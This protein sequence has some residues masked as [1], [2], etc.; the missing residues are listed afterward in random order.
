MSGVYHRL[1]KPATSSVRKP[2]ASV[3]GS[4]HAN[5]RSTSAQDRP[6]REPPGTTPSRGPERVRRGASPAPLPW[7]E[8]A[9]GTMSPVLGRP[10]RALRSH[11]VKPEWGKAPRRRESRQWHRERPDRTKRGAPR[12]DTRHAREARRR[13][14]PRHTDRCQATAAAKCC[15]PGKRAQQATNHVKRTG[16]KQHQPPSGQTSEHPAVNPS[17]A[18]YG[19]AAVQM[20][21][22]APKRYPA[23]AGYET[24]AVRM[25]VCAPGGYPD[26]A[27]Y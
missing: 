18:G 10:P 19:T 16:P 13:P 3:I 20:E 22:C 8:P 14:K 27:G 17:P 5:H 7:R 26:P 1:L 24:A 9:A 6:W 2:N 15:K 4:G 12:G 23:P 25:D 11:Q 21:E